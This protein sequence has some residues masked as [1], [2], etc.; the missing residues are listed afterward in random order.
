VAAWTVSS[1]S[2]W[3]A[4]RLDVEPKGGVDHQRD[5]TSS[6]TARGLVHRYRSDDGLDGQ[7][8]AFLLCT[9]SLTEALV[10]AGRPDEARQVFEPT[11][12]YRSDVALLSEEVDVPPGELIGNFPQSLGDQRAH[13]SR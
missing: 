2:S 8:G 9:F 11:V 5:E 10:R 3:E 7:E 12:G 4:P 13:S 1:T 6:P